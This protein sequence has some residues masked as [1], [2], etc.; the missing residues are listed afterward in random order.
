[1]TGLA[2]LRMVRGTLH[3]LYACSLMH[4]TQRLPFH[5]GPKESEPVQRI[6]NKALVDSVA[7]TARVN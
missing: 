3:R 5:A 6:P 7:D 4:R 2:E 1:M